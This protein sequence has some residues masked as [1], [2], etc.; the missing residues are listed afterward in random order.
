VARRTQ[1][2]LLVALTIVWALWAGWSLI[3]RETP[4]TVR[5]LD[6]QGAPVAQASIDVEGKQIGTSTGDGTIDVE[7]NRSTTVLEV[8]APGHIS[9]MVTVTERPGSVMDIVLKARVLRGRVTDASGKPVESA[10]VVA[11]PATGA[12][13]EEGRFSLRGAEPGPVQ[14]SRPAWIE[15]GFTWDGGVGESVVEMEPFVAR[16]VHISGEAAGQNI[17]YF[18]D[19]AESTELNALMLDLKDESGLVWYD[20]ADPVATEVGAVEGVY[21]LG[22]IA[23]RAEEADLYV[24]GRLVVFNDPTAAIRKPSMAVWNSASNQPYQAN[25]QYFL[26]P[27]DPE[28]RAYGLSLAVEACEMGVDEVQFDYVRF[29]DQRSE[30]TVFDS[31]VGVEVRTATITDFLREAVGLLH[32]MGCAVAADVFGFTTAPG[33]DDGGIGQRWEDV[34]EVVDVASPMV[35]PSHYGPDWYGYENPNDHPGPMVTRAIE[36]GLERLPRNVVIRPWLQDFGY[37]PEQVRQQIESVE[38][39]G[40]GWMLWNARSTVSVDA[41]SRVE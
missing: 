12:T 10:I 26:D 17:E 24:I 9:Q 1:F 34:T 41:L 21:D 16:A 5:V 20:S 4:Y 29:P 2:R 11:G 8:S 35:Y 27:T 39:F 23:A 6:D 32:P 7:W 15:T 40:L 38:R 13:D 28:A 36:D 25:G 19:M 37:T 18:F 14:V 33:T 30:E 22:E 31:G 3:G